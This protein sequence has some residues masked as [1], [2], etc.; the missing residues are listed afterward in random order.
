MRF[1]AVL[2]VILAG[3]G[4][5]PPTAPPGAGEGPDGDGTG[6]EGPAAEWRSISGAYYH[7]CGLT[8]ERAVHCWGQNHYGQLG[9]GTT[10]AGGSEQVLVSGGHTWASVSAGKRISCG[11]TTAAEAYCWGYGSTGALGDGSGQ[12]SS[13]PVRVAGGQSWREISVSSGSANACA[14]TTSG[15]AYCWG[16]NPYGQVGN[17]ERGVDGDPMR[18]YTPYHVPL[19]GTVEAIRG[20]SGHTCATTSTGAGYCWGDNKYGQLGR[21]IGSD[22]ATPGEVLGGVTWASLNPYGSG[23][24]GLSTDGTVYGLTRSGA[25]PLGRADSLK[26]FHPGADFCALTDSG[27]AYCGSSTQLFDDFQAILDQELGGY[28]WAELDPGLGVT[29]G[30]TTDG[31]GFC[32]GA[33]TYGQLGPGTD[34]D[35][36]A[37]PVEVPIPE[38]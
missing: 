31:R 5:L 9:D 6:G 27:T 26:S 28:A 3:C 13:T 8:T 38:R 20:G 37:D 25:E 35:R 23:T 1:L 16:H 10:G 4:E 19:P 36:A 34:A 24:Y 14:I 32:W 29:C 15:D 2:A 18:V 17:G 21:P 12:H 30:V 22:Q 33:N 11:I 7:S